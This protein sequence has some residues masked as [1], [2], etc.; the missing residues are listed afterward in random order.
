MKIAPVAEV[1]ARFS[2]YVRASGDGPIIVTRNGRPVA[3]LIGV[4]D[5]D[6]DELEGL[7]LAHSS[8]FRKVLEQARTEIGRTGGIPHET[9]W[10]EVEEE[11][12]R[13]KR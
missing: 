9:F 5:K 13:R 1:E 10:D 8:P 2:E 11:P 3:V 7:L 12:E 6:E 4:E